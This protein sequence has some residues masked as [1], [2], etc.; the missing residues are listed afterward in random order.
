M[1]I[2]VVL[3][4]VVKIRQ[5]TARGSRIGGD[6]VIEA[7]SIADYLAEY[8]KAEPHVGIVS[9]YQQFYLSL[10]KEAIKDKS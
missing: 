2:D 8:I 5:I 10:L 3:Q 9:S 1:D 7:N 6:E 4:A